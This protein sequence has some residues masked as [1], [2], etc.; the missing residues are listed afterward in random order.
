M[1]PPTTTPHLVRENVKHEAINIE[2]WRHSFI[3]LSHVSSCSYCTVAIFVAETGKQ[4]APLDLFCSCEPVSSSL[5]HLA[6]HKSGLG[7]AD[8]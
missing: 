6:A 2:K 4:V 8:V 5:L 7:T 3:L 1:P